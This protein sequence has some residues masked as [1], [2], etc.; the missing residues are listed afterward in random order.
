[1]MILLRFPGR[2]LKVSPSLF[3]LSMAKCERSGK[4]KNEL[5]N[6]KEAGLSVKKSNWFSFSVSPDVK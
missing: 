5:L 2:I 1:M 3:L 4:Q 6:I